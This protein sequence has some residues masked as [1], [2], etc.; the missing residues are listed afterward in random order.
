MSVWKTK[1]ITNYGIQET[2]YLC[3]K[4]NIYYPARYFNNLVNCASMRNFVQDD[5]GH[6]FPCASCVFDVCVRIQD[7][8]GKWIQK[9]LESDRN[10]LPPDGFPNGLP[11]NVVER[12]A[13]K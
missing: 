9:G 13:R 11:P 3:Y 10:G 5:G 2:V 7:E 6:L 8:S 12:N 1:E 4:C